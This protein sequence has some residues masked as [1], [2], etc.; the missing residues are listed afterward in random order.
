MRSGVSS[1]TSEQGVLFRGKDIGAVKLYQK[2]NTGDTRDMARDKTVGQNPLGMDNIGFLLFHESQKCT[3]SKNEKKRRKH[4]H[5][6]SE[7]YIPFDS[8]RITEYM[9]AIRQDITVG[10][11]VNIMVSG[12]A[13]PF[14]VIGGQYR[15]IVFKAGNVFHEMFNKGS[16]DIIGETWICMGD[17]R[18]GI[19]R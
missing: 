9:Q 7:F 10:A 1:H 13:V 15:N 6:F 12:S 5:S 18:R 2:R 14:G 3:V 17:A 11:Q 19:A 8:T 16:I 4:K